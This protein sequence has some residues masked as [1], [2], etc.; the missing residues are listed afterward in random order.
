M[1]FDKSLD[2]LLYAGD[3][4]ITAN[5]EDEPNQEDWPNQEWRSMNPRIRCYMQATVI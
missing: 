3:S 2:S 5:Q 1:A 4:D